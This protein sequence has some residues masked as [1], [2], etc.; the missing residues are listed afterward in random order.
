VEQMHLAHAAVL[1]AA[2]GQFFHE[3]KL[4]RAGWAAH[5][6]ET[7][8]DVQQDQWS[9]ISQPDGQ[10]SLACTV[11]GEAAL[12]LLL[13][14]AKP[15]VVFGKNGVSRKGKSAEAASHY[16]TFPR[17]ESSGSLRLGAETHEV[18][19]N[20]WMDHEFSSSQLDEGQVGWDWAAIQLQD[21]SEI[22]AYRMRRVDGSTDPF[23][24]LATIDPAG[25]VQHHDAEHFQWQALSTWTSPRSQAVY[26]TQVRITWAEQDLRLR[27]VA[28][29]QEQ[30]GSITGLPYWEG[31]CDVLDV[32]D[33][34]VGR[35]FLELAGYGGDLSRHLGGK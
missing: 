21:G 2:S 18:K 33:E 34:V 13:K 35:A 25:R 11:R 3:E 9:L 14:P 1:D 20:A 10:I 24:T 27:P 28:A 23:S 5:A 17:L 26:P 7:Q 15:L 8:L 29:D 6:A 31:A 19:G 30:G 22:M 12:Q 16:L 4:Q 32:K